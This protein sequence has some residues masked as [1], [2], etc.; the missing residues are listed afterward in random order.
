MA[1]TISLLTPHMI[2]THYSTATNLLTATHL[3]SLPRQNRPINQTHYPAS[4][5]HRPQLCPAALPH[6]HHHHIFILADYVPKFPRIVDTPVKDFISSDVPLLPGFNADDMNQLFLPDLISTDTI[7]FLLL[8]ISL[9][10][11]V[12]Y[13]ELGALLS[14]FMQE[15]ELEK[16][17]ER[18][19][20]DEDDRRRGIQ[21]LNSSSKPEEI[22]MRERKRGLGWLAFI[23]ASAIWCT[24]ILNKVNP[25]QP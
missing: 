1:P 25:F 17:E 13:L 4:H 11:A 20:Q 12:V 22:A 23:T 16:L 5:R 2:S 19:L 7:Y 21:N 3:A 9:A 24:G 18:Y 10:V 8:C 6:H 14:D 15:Q